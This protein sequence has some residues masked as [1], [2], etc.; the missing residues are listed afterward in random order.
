MKTLI[1]TSNKKNWMDVN[2]ILSFDS[3]NSLG[4]RQ[5]IFDLRLPIQENEISAISFINEQLFTR[6]ISECKLL[7]RR[8]EDLWKISTAS[9]WD[10]FSDIT[11]LPTLGDLGYDGKWYFGNG[12]GKLS[13]WE[14]SLVSRYNFGLDTDM[15]WVSDPL[16]AEQY[17]SNLAKQAIALVEESQKK[18]I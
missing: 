16:L 2:V 13:D 3:L 7:N 11:S 10:T 18:G 8:A 6:I 15:S 12:A 14:E 5:E 9:D 4:S 1:N 17:M